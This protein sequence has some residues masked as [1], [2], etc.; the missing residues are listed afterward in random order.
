MGLL[1]RVTGVGILIGGKRLILG[2]SIDLSCRGLEVG[3]IES[4]VANT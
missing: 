2:V 3:R 4:I 1:Y